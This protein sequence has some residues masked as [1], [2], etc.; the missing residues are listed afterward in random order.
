VVLHDR[1]GV[2]AENLG[3]PQIDPSGPLALGQ[4]LDRA[5]S[6][7]SDTLLVYYAG[8]GLIGS[9]QE[10][11]LATGATDSLVDGL[12]FKALS[13]RVLLRSLRKSQARTVVVV[14]DCCFSDRGWPP[15]RLPID[16]VFERTL[17]H[18][19]FLLTSA[20]RDE[21]ALAAVGERH[22]RFTGALIRLLRDGDPAGPRGLTL[23]HAYRFLNRELPA[24]TPRPH[25]HSTDGAGEL[26]LAPNP[27]YRSRPAE[28]SGDW[29]PGDSLSDADAADGAAAGAELPC[30]FRGLRPFG[31]EDAEYFFGRDD[32][33][34]EVT[35][36]V[37]GTDGLHA[38]IGP[39]GSGKTSLLRAGAIP[40][41]LEQGWRVAV[42]TPGGDP[43]AS[44]AAR[45]DALSDSGGLLVVDQFEELFAAE[46]A[47]DDRK[48]F[49]HRLAR[50]P[51][52]VIALRADFYGQCLRY[53]ELV[54]ALRENQVIV[55]PMNK[56]DL[57][58]MIRESAKKA[59]LRLEHGLADTLLSEVGLR[60]TRN[61]GAALPLLS[62]ALQETWLRRSGNLLTLAGYR[63]TGGIEKAIGQAAQ[64][65]YDDMDTA[66]QLRMR[67]LLLRMVRLCDDTDDTRRQVPLA[68]LSAPDHRILD[69]LAG[70]RLA[71]IGDEEAELAHDAMLYAWPQLREWITEN[72][73]ALLA[74]GQLEDA[75]RAWEQAGFGDEY[76]YPG[77]RLDA[78]EK[79]LAGAGTTP[80]LEE[81]TR[82]F[83]EASRAR[84]RAEEQA[85]RRGRQRRRVILSAI[86][87]LVLAAGTVGVISVQQHAA[88]AQH[89]AVIQ[90]SDLA[91]DAAALQ[92]TDP[93]LAAQLSVAAYRTSPTES[94][95]TQL[96]A[97]ASLPVDSTVGSVGQRVVAVT[98][99]AD[100]PLVAASD[101]GGRLL[102]VWSIASPS[103]P[104]LQAEITVRLPEGKY[105]TLALAPRQ[106]L[107]VARCSASAV[108]LW[109][110]AERGAPAVAGRIPLFVGPGGPARIT[111]MRFSPDGRLLALGS[112]NDGTLLYTIA[113]P[114]R[115]RLLAV[116]PDMP[117]KRGSHLGGVA[118]SPDGRLLAQTVQTGATKLWSLTDPAR[119]EQAAS[120]ASGYQDVAFSP[121]GTML[122]AV[123]D[124]NVGLWNIT[125]PTR[126]S[127][128]PIPSSDTGTVT[129]TY[130]E[131]L[132][133]V[134]FTPD[135]RYLAYTGDPVGEDGLGVLGLL[136][137]SPASLSNPIPMIENTE[138]GNGAMTP[139]GGDTLLTGGTDGVVRL[140]RTPEPEATGTQAGGPTDW[141]VSGDG[142][143]MAAPIQLASSPAG[144]PD[145]G[146]WNISGKTPVLDATLPVDPATAAFLGNASGALLTD[147]LDGGVTLW[148]V[149]DP[150]HPVRA[151]SLGSAV[152]SDVSRGSPDGVVTSDTAGTLTAV[153][154]A[155]G[156]L[157]LWRVGNGP[158][159]T[160]AGSIRVPDPRTDLAGVLP[161]GQHA[162]IITPQG[163]QWWDIADPAQPA[164]IGSSPM[165]T[166]NKG[167]GTGGG[168]LFAETDQL[169]N[170]CNCSKLDIYS[171][172][173]R[174][175]TSSA[176][177][178]GQ[179]GGQLQVSSD[180]RL[181]ASAGAGGNGLTLWDLRDP[182]QPRELAA[183]QTVPTITGVTLSPNDALLADWNE[184]TLQLWSLRDPASPALVASIG[185]QAQQYVANTLYEVLGGAE[186]ASSGGTLAV[187]AN[188]SVVFLD[189]DPAAVASRLCAVTGA[190]ITHAQ[191]QLYA[192]GIPYQDPC[193][194][195]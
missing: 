164:R 89:A 107:L 24:G 124:T 178:S 8:H 92:S 176:T 66:G 93:G 41:L 114:A 74:A 149:T 19:G 101:T 51:A 91:A 86:C 135:G 7:A 181:L 102:H 82:R 171:L 167:S 152:L 163:L 128:V 111:S 110:V 156:L 27:A 54:R 50:L 169:D 80:R 78:A 69:A 52:V 112:M 155:D 94:A 1:V 173:G 184:Q 26:V 16:A 58:L 90:S 2:G 122:A 186:F 123:G 13:Y 21:L 100:G 60:E 145:T 133:A 131:D 191:W 11:Y 70:A 113:S 81:G 165:A 127:S 146:I 188:Y 99:Q 65:V 105:T 160:L 5:A 192:P 9:D 34:R 53:P 179:A 40:Q 84:Q 47:E 118:F 3:E 117:S 49:L 39:S 172:S 120:I 42:M 177:L 141:S 187:S 119:P 25:R 180:G 142:H 6:E 134:A 132:H 154:G 55:G 153:L 44:L 23:D 144:T 157:R 77:T 147:D 67:D 35:R 115:P 28:K 30:P 98:G 4:A 137:V 46:V 130:S 85:A 20:A 73:A 143:L 195:I 15:A 33:I 121:D 72:R 151:A 168:S 182:S 95:A 18:G 12:D 193:R 162:V 136:D 17:V 87:A 61:Q 37:N 194:G 48:R 36:C 116:L 175:V 161:D 10:L 29:R 38:V 170:L 185:F 174:H 166:A 63:D 138:F 64:R 159:V 59:G 158:K 126:P 108:C 109:N 129:S 71:V 57:H 32:L 83:I 104:V 45:E 148:N 68:Q 96:Y 190:A 106:P 97:S 125:R 79:K 150:R 103:A 75:A 88:A 14:L 43:L 140:W 76:L 189:T 56:D 31:P 22:T 62:H 139:A 183:L